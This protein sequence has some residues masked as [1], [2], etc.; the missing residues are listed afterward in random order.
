MIEQAVHRLKEKRVAP[1]AKEDV[2]VAVEKPPILQ[3]IRDGAVHTITGFRLFIK[4]VKLSTRYLV[5]SLRGQ[6]LSRRER[7]LV[8]VHIC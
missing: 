7:K 4:D 1:V 3:R 8:S 6:Q 2:E 5:K